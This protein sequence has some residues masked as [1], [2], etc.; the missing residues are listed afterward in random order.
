MFRSSIGKKEAEA[1]RGIAAVDVARLVSMAA[2]FS[3]EGML[4]ALEECPV[5]ELPVVAGDNLL[6]TNHKAP[7]YTCTM[8][9]R[10]IMVG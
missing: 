9:V 6:A 5:D 2:I 10:G 4:H 1:A 7:C 8:A 3:G